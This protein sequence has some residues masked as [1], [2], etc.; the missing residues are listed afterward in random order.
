MSLT[1]IPDQKAT[2]SS[3]KTIQVF[4]QYNSRPLELNSSALTAMTG[5]LESKGFGSDSAESLSITILTQAKADGYNPFTILETMKSLSNVELS[6]FVGEIINYNR[7]KTSTLGKTQ[8]ITPVDDVS[9][10][11]L[12]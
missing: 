8:K 9:R 7:L 12:I 3:D 6:S 2:S 10:N 5:F 1:N 4:N 11:I